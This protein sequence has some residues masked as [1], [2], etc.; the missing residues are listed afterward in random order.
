MPAARPKGTS[1]RQ[2]SRIV[3]EAYI[4]SRR[5]IHTSLRADGPGFRIVR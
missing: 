4:T 5:I 2:D 3:G 1:Q